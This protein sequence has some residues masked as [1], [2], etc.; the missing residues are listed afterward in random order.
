MSDKQP[1][2]KPLT[3]LVAVFFVE[4]VYFNGEQSS[5]AVGRNT[6]SIAP[7]RLLPDGSAVAIDTNQRADGLVLTKKTHNLATHEKHIKRCFVPF[8]NIRC[9]E[10]GE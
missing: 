3:K 5:A 7:A 1:E 4:S 6:D 9:L 10:Y 2:F 8:A